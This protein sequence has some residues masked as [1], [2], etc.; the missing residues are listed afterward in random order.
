[1]GVLITTFGKIWFVMM[2]L[3]FFVCGWLFVFKT[4]MMVR[5]GRESYA[6]REFLRKAPNANIVLK[7]WYQH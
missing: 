7:S 4:E 3:F 5:M 1:M 2:T 6:K